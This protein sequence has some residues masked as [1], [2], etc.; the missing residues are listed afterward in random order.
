VNRELE[1]I[2]V[3]IETWLERHAPAIAKRFGRPAKAAEIAATERFL[4]VEFPDDIRESYLR[5]NGHPS[6]MG[7]DEWLSLEGIRCWWNTGHSQGTGLIPLTSDEL[8]DFCVDLASKPRRKYGQIVATYRGKCEG[9]VATAFRTW[10]E[11]FAAE[12]E[13]FEYYPDSVEH[14]LE[15]MHG[16]GV[17]LSRG[18]ER[19]SQEWWQFVL[20]LAVLYG[21]KPAGTDGHTAAPGDSLTKLNYFNR[22]DGEIVTGPDAIALGQ[23]IERLVAGFPNRVSKR[24]APALQAIR[25]FNPKKRASLTRLAKFCKRGSFTI[26]I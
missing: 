5:H 22:D 3:R 25:Y 24:L 17:T 4:G 11:R 23:A 6:L 20:E 26:G 9:A 14:N 18:R 7:G 10:L 21:W 12:L 13:A 1:R 2:W 15:S 16:Y 19:L 8:G